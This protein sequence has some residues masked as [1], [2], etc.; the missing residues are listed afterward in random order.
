MANHSLESVVPRKGHSFLKNSQTKGVPLCIN[1]GGDTTYD[2]VL[3]IQ[4][5]RQMCDA[6]V[7]DIS[8]AFVSV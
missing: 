2:I 5:K 7:F 1:S 8:T 6:V 4:G 3:L